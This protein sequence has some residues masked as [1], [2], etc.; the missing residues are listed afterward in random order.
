MKLRLANRED[1]PR[2][3]DIYNTT[4]ASRMVTADLEPVSYESREKW[5]DDHTDR[6]PLWVAEENG[7]ITSWVSLQPFYGREAYKHTAEVSIYI[8]PAFRGAG[9]GKKLLQA[10]IDEC[11]GL[12]IYTL[13]GFV[14]GHNE[15]SIRLFERFGFSRWGTFP[16]IAELEGVER[17][18]VILGKRVK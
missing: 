8:D 7:A 15:P 6:Y 17:D 9:L 5:F 2:I 1:L 11:A 4:I 3:V 13:L 10:A 18:L 12:D 14:F 16:G